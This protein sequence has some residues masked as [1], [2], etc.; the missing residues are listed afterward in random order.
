MSYTGLLQ[1]SKK[2]L[3]HNM[4]VPKAIIRNIAVA[5][6]LTTSLEKQYFQREIPFS[7]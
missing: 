3:L 1:K 5:S 6:Q 2:T 4:P 7:M